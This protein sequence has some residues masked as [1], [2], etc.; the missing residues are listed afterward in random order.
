V[1][2]TIWFLVLHHTLL[3]QAGKVIPVYIVAGDR[4]NLTSKLRRTLSRQTFEVQ[5][6]GMHGQHSI[7]T[8][9]VPTFL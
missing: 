4:V 8:V 2:V 1:P 5:P 3:Y 7:L 9:S 6:S